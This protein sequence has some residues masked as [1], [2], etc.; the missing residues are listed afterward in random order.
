MT[1]RNK[2]KIEQT[3][4]S[5]N[6]E[7]LTDLDI[8]NAQTRVWNHLGEAFPNTKVTGKHISSSNIFRNSFFQA[9]FGALALG[10]SAFILVLALLPGTLKAPIV[11]SPTDPVTALK[12][13]AAKEFLSRT[14]A[15]Y[16][17]V[18]EIITNTNVDNAPISASAFSSA[19]S[20]NNKKAQVI[21]DKN[22]NISYYE[23]E[24]TN[25][26]SNSITKV[27]TW[28]SPTYS[29]SIMWVDGKISSASLQTPDLNLLYMGGK[30]AIRAK[31]TVSQYTNALSSYTSSDPDIDFIKSILDDV[32]GQFKYIGTDTVNGQQASVFEQKLDF[33]PEK[34]SAPSNGVKT[35]SIAVPADPISTQ[36]VSQKIRYFINTDD[37][38]ILRVDMYQG[39]KVVTSTITKK[40]QTI[41][42][43]DFKK[44]LYDEF[45]EITIKDTTYDNSLET[46]FADTVNKNKYIYVDN[47]V[48][49]SN[50]YIP[51]AYYESE[52][53]KLITSPDFQTNNSQSSSTNPAP[54]DGKAIDISGLSLFTYSQNVFG[55]TG[56]AI[57]PERKLKEYDMTKASVKIDGQ[58]LDAESF[59]YKAVN[60]KMEITPSV[61]ISS[62]SVS[63]SSGSSGSNIAVLP[64][65]TPND[66]VEIIFN[67]G[68]VWYDLY[69]SKTQALSFMSMTPAKAKE[70]DEY[71]KAKTNALPQTQS[72][73]LSDVPAAVRILP[74]DL[75]AIYSL[76][77]GNIQK[78][79][80]AGNDSTCDKFYLVDYYYVEV[81]CLVEKYDGFSIDFYSTAMSVGG[82]VRA[83]DCPDMISGGNVSSSC[84]SLVY[85]QYVTYLVLNLPDG[86]NVADLLKMSKDL[87]ANFAFAQAKK[88][89]LTVVAMGNVGD[90]DNAKNLQQIVDN[91]AQDKDLDILIKQITSGGNVKPLAK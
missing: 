71:N 55:Y 20:A 76:K 47:G 61:A 12:L 4:Q 78:S 40:N 5:M 41:S 62:S 81:Q 44:T 59:T 82:P 89:G 18:K 60:Q 90:K 39:D 49:P 31:Y 52:Y 85:S 21:T 87:P 3:L 6:R 7:P 37:F 48:V 24:I 64:K 65:Q 15:S 51:S 16:Q 22:T 14:G 74:G 79:N 34:I 27:A 26:G 75:S 73:N 77:I 72:I 43:D 8:Q 35:N 1:K 11:N 80:K 10:I 88:N 58:N 46:N 70:F 19:S 57:K 17:D 67:Y 84:A 13:Q 68:G 56:Y 32:N 38:K 28:T 25:S 50:L 9:G 42:L 91:S 29:K 83:V 30:Y 2:I 63:S 45:I 69:A 53:Y 33:V 23:Q 36:P 86:V 54:A 66:Q